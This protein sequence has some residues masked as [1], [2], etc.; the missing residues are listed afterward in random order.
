MQEDIIRLLKE[1]NIEL[2]RTKIDTNEEEIYRICDDERLIFLIE[3]GSYDN[4]ILEN[5]VNILMDWLIYTERSIEKDIVSEY[6][7]PYTMRKILWDLYVI[8]IVTEKNSI[9]P[10]EKYRVQRDSRYMKRY[11][12]QEKTVNEIVKRIGYIVKPE[13]KIDEYINRL[14]FTN[15]EQEHCKKMSDWKNIDNVKY[16]FKGDTYKE[17]LDT[18]AKINKDSFGDN[19]NEDKRD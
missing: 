11:I 16:S 6:L 12:V 17:I 4:A 14:E 7:E 5:Y 10:E 15:K 1:E 19:V 13:K 2:E 8:F 3:L 18:L 9:L